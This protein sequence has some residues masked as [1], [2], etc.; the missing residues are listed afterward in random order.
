[1]FGLPRLFW[2][3]RC[4]IFAN[5]WAPALVW[6]LRVLHFCWCLGSRACF[7]AAGASFLRM[8]GLPLMFWCLRCFI[9]AN[10]WAPALVLVPPMLHFCECLGFRAC[11]SASG[12]SFLR[13]LGLPRLFW[14]LR[15]FFLANAW[16]LVRVLVFPL[17]FFN[18]VWAP[19]LVLWRQLVN[20]D[21]VS[22]GL[23]SLTASGIQLI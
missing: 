15:C 7:P 13:M 23:S 2:C 10:V 14:C 18:N 1:M 20:L 17:S 19:V 21:N 3:L 16:A 6:V 9:F 8:F 11:F 22:I 4:F 5:V 12:A